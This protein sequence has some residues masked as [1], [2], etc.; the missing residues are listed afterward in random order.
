MFFHH[1]G[2]PYGGSFHL[3]F[4]LALLFFAIWWLLIALVTVRLVRERGEH[5]SLWPLIAVLIGPL[6]LFAALL[7]PTRQ[8]DRAEAPTVADDEN[9]PETSA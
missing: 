6:A 3:L 5:S 4:G 9:K 7:L 2:G 1:L 8:L